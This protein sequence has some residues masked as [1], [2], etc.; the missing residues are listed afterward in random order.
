MSKN[1]DQLVSP[2]EPVIRHASSRL[3]V[4]EQAPPMRG[5][6]AD[7]LHGLADGT[8][9]LRLPSPAGEWVTR[10]D[11]HFHLAPELFLQVAGWTRFRFPHGELLLGPGEALVMPPKL[12]HAERVGAGEDGTPFCNIVVYAEGTTLI[13]H[14]AHEEAPGTPGI[15]HLEARHH[16]QAQSIHDWL[17]DAAKL[18]RASMARV[19]AGEGLDCAAIQ[20][21]ALVV[22]ATAGVLRLLD[23]PAAD[24]RQEPPLVARVR[25]LIQNQLGDHQLSVRRLAEQS[26]CTA[27]YLSHVF[28]QATGEHLAG[29]INRQRME[30]ATRL[31]SESG[32]AGKEVAWA[33]G[34][35]TQS[36]F[37][38]TF[39]AHFGMTPKVWRAGRGEG[40]GAAVPAAV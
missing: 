15:L 20:A 30:R 2:L 10:G 5:Q 29:F 22:A 33:C 11:G 3:V 19:D 23:D 35:A 21:R 31:L 14:V 28:R 1:L 39:R 26:G 37:I 38:R 18:G 8:R 36:Y 12:L 13:C 7:F 27:D 4:S 40:A 16:A 24:P 34:F 6:L 9:P 32:L 17:A 25:V